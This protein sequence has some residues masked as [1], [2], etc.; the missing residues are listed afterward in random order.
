MLIGNAEPARLEAGVE[1]MTDARADD[2][3]AHRLVAQDPGRRVGGQR[4]VQVGGHPP[5]LLDDREALHAARAVEREVVAYEHAEL[6]LVGGARIGRRRLSLAI[7]TGQ[8]AAFE[9]APDDRA[10]AEAL[11]DRKHVALDVAR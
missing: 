11:A 1:M 8:P 3:S 10:E 5:P 9:G 7:A 4:R 6:G 2:R